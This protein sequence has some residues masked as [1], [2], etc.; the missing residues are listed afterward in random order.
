VTELK[1]V[2]ILRRDGKAYPYPELF[3]TVAAVEETFPRETRRVAAVVSVHIPPEPIK[4][5]PFDM[6]VRLM[7]STSSGIADIYKNPDGT[8]VVNGV[9]Y[10]QTTE[11]P[12]T[13]E[14]GKKLLQ[15]SYDR[16][17]H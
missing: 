15:E 4:I 7:D 6:Y 17:F 13:T 16:A 9:C 11:A 12:V 8:L 2:A 14:Q 5:H 1:Y 10:D 3:D